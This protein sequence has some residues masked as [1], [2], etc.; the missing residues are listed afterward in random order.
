[1][2]VLSGEGCKI[3]A[4][5][6]ERPDSS[7]SSLLFFA[8]PP[9]F[10]LNFWNILSPENYPASFFY[11]FNVTSVFATLCRSSH[12]RHY[13]CNILICFFCCQIF[14]GYC[15]LHPP[16]LVFIVY[17]YQLILK[18]VVFICPNSLQ[19]S[20]SHLNILESLKFL[21]LVNLALLCTL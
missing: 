18:L 19:V 20:L 21:G 14:E 2:C 1:M 6:N 8:F 16:T 17:Q 15:S 12:W 13:G 4:L 3:K 9:P 5:P 7:K 11:I 10:C